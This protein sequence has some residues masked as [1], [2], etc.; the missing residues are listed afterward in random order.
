MM[1]AAIGAPSEPGVRPKL[2]SREH[3]NGVRPNRPRCFQGLFK[4]PG[5]SACPPAGKGRYVLFLRF[6]CASHFPQRPPFW[7]MGNTCTKPPLPDSRHF[8]APARHISP[9]GL[10][11]LPESRPYSR[12]VSL[13]FS[14]L[15]RHHIRN[16]R[17]HTGKRKAHTNLIPRPP[18]SPNRQGYSAVESRPK[19]SLISFELALLFFLRNQTAPA[20]V[21]EKGQRNLPGPQP[22]NCTPPMLGAP[23]LCRPNGGPQGP[24]QTGIHGLAPSTTKLRQGFSF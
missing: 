3:H 4:Q 16:S 9:K 13:R 10:V 21:L 11:P 12:P 7:P 22:P 24:P 6:E 1:I 5:K 2:P 15:N 20:R 23:R 17:L 8:A 18:A 14:S 19:H